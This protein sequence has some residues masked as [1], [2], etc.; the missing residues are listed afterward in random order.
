[1]F[2]LAS[3]HCSSPH[4]PQQSPLQHEQLDLS[5]WTRCI[6]TDIHRFATFVRLLLTKDRIAGVADDVVD[7]PGRCDLYGAWTATPLAV[8]DCVS[9]LAVW[10]KTPP[11]SSFGYCVD[12]QSGFVVSQPDQLVS[13]TTVT[14]AVFCQRKS[15][16]AERY[17]GVDGP[18]RVMFVGTFVHELFQ[19]AIR[20]A[21]NGVTVSKQTVQRILDGMLCESHLLVSLY[22]TRMSIAELRDEMSKF[23]PRI[24]HFMERFFGGSENARMLKGIP[25]VPSDKDDFDGRIERVLDIEENIWIP[26][27]GLKGKVDVTASIC[28]KSNNMWQ[29]KSHAKGWTNLMFNNNLFFNIIIDPLL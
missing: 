5:T 16:L 12:M 2:F 3:D 6:I 18:N 9:I 27:M 13:G 26:A 29:N 15:V 28:R 4:E 11:S 8:G 14:G 22:E 10:Q 24:V 19:S 7:L 17:P 1:M 20:L 23:V 21:G 25:A